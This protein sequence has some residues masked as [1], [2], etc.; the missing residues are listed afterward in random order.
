MIELRVREQVVD[1][2]VERRGRSVTCAGSSRSMNS[3]IG[4]VELTRAGVD[5]GQQIRDAGGEQEN[6]RQRG[7]DDVERDSAGEEQHVVFAAVVPD[8]LDVVAERPAKVDEEVDGSGPALGEGARTSAELS[9][10]AVVR[11]VDSD[12]RATRSAQPPRRRCTP[13]SSRRCVARARR[14]L[15]CAAARPASMA[16]VHLLALHV[17]RV[18]RRIDLLFDAAARVVEGVD[19]RVGDVGRDILGRACAR[20]SRASLDVASRRLA[21]T[22]REQQRDAGA[23]REPNEKRHRCLIGVA[24]D[25][26]VRRSSSSKSIRV[27]CWVPLALALLVGGRLLDR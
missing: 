24:L 8:A 16:R 11:L 27:T 15:R 6:E 25:H 13:P 26:Y 22:R 12:S 10:V 7:E 1:H 20:A 23:E 17:E 18:A 21:R 3:T 2:L 5:E 9:S 14:A 4:R 19:D